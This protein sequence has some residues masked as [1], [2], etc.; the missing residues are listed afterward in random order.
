[1]LQMSHQ[2]LFR[3]PAREVELQH[4]QSAKGWFAPGPQ[5]NEQTGNE[6]QVDLD[7]DAVQTVGQQMTTTEDALEPAKKE[8]RLP[9]IMPP[10]RGAYIGFHGRLRHLP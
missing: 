4:L 6:G 5:A 9:T 8:F 10:K 7:R 3:G 1:M 2:F